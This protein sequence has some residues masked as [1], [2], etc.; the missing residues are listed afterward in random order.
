MENALSALIENRIIDASVVFNNGKKFEC[1]YQLYGGDLDENSFR[2]LLRHKLIRKFE[3]KMSSP[4]KDFTK[5]AEEYQYDIIE[6]DMEDSEVQ[7]F[8][9]CLTENIKSIY[10]LTHTDIKVTNLALQAIDKDNVIRCD[11]DLDG[12]DALMFYQMK[13]KADGSY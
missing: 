3:Y 8:C 11:V 13:R 1:L 7:K 10:N 5:E 4:E 12:I 2:D 6:M 9:S